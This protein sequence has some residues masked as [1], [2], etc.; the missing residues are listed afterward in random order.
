MAFRQTSL[1]VFAKGA[2][3]FAWFKL[4][5]RIIK[6]KLLWNGIMGKNET[7]NVSRKF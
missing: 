7:M 1:P 6:G 5:H 2:A 4:D 3:Y